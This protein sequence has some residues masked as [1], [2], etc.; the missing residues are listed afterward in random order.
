MIRIL[1]SPSRYQ[2]TIHLAT[3][4]NDYPEHEWERIEIDA[5]VTPIQDMLQEAYTYTLDGKRRVLLIQNA[6]FLTSARKPSIESNQDFSSFERVFEQ[7]L[8]HPHMIFLCEDDVDGKNKWV[9][10]MKQS[11]DVTVLPPLKK[12]AW[13]E[14]IQLPIQKRGIQ[15]SSHAKLLFIDRLYPDID[16]AI[17]ELDKLSL[18]EQP[19]TDA[20]IKQWIPQ[21]LETNVFEFSNAVVQGH[22]GDALRIFRDLTLQRVE[23]V[24]F[25]SMLGRQF[26]LM[27][28]VY[29]LDEKGLSQS[30]ISQSLNIHE[31]RVKLI[32]QGKRL[33][34]LDRVEEAIVSLADLDYHIKSG[35]KDRFQAFEFWLLHR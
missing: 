20:H 9:K 11:G 15:W 28:T 22:V 18:L 23:P 16:R 24:T 13:N 34:P 25:I 35:Q 2:Q 10:L 29:A 33:F 31:Y 7:T 6:Y 21:S 17:Q 19:L 12:P 3:W 32:L 26:M 1:V 4:M 27:E 14:L 5:L 30:A 8:D